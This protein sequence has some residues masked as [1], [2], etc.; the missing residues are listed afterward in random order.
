MDVALFTLG[1]V[2]IQAKRTGENEKKRLGS[3]TKP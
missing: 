2:L 1:I 3:K